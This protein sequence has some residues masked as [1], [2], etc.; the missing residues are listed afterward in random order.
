M[1]RLMIAW[2]VIGV[3]VLVFSSNTPPQYEGRKRC[4]RVLQ[5]TKNT[6]EGS[7]NH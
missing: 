2:F 1:A 7:S 6:D 3:P 4:Y 5:K